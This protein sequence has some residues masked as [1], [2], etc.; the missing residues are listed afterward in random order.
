MTISRLLIVTITSVLFNTGVLLNTASAIA[1][2]GIMVIVC[3]AIGITISLTA[4]KFD[5]LSSPFTVGDL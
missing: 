1:W 2:D 5:V 3:E 4:D